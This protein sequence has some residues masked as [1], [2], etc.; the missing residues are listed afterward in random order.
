MQVKRLL[1]Q[2]S[3]LCC[4]A[5][6]SHVMAEP[7]LKCCRWWSVINDNDQLTFIASPVYDWMFLQRVKSKS[8]LERWV[9]FPLSRLTR[10]ACDWWS[11][12]TS[13]TF[14]VSHWERA[15]PTV[16]EV[17]SGW[18]WPVSVTFMAW[19]FNLEWNQFGIICHPDISTPSSVLKFSVQTS[20]MHFTFSKI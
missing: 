17:A 3:E 16:N 13:T 5:P 19:C 2:K 4:S 10:C 15:V 11:S 12:H 1:F 18:W 9:T 20:Q 7:F 6:W 14:E 8:P